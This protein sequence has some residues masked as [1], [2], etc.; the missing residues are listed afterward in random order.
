MKKEEIFNKKLNN[1]N[2]ILAGIGI[3]NKVINIFFHVLK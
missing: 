3:K 1:L 2:E